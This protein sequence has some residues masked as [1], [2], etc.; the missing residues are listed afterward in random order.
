MMV[1][2]SNVQSIE[3]LLARVMKSKEMDGQRL[4]QADSHTHISLSTRLPQGPGRA[5]GDGSS[6]GQQQRCDDIG[7]AGGSVANSENIDE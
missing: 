1:C 3:M 7:R 5:R 2:S 4:L 6:I